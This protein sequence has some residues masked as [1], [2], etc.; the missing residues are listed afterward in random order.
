MQT[1]LFFVLGVA[2][3]NGMFSP[4]LRIV[5]LFAPVWYPALLPQVASLLFLLS[6]LLVATFTLMI[7]G[8]PAAIFE[9]LSGRPDSDVVSMGIWLLGVLI[10]TAP[11]IANMLAAMA[12]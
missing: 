2:M 4:A 11:A 1:G 10:L 5:V 8:I 3:L 9:R 12:G 6:S 7:A